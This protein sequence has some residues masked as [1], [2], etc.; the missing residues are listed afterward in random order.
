MT[1]PHVAVT[2]VR[3]FLVGAGLSNWVIV[4]VETDEGVHGVGDATLE[5]QSTAVAKLIDELKEPYLMEKSVFEIERFVSTVYAS[6]FWRGGPV[7]TSA[8]SGIEIAMWDAVGKLLGQS[9]F[10]LLGGRCHETI[11]AY[12][13]AWYRTSD[14]P[15][16]FA[17]EAT[18]VVERGYDAL[19]LDPLGS[20]QG[21]F[22]EQEF[23]NAVEI[24]RRIRKRVGDD[25]DI[26]VETHGRL[27]P[28]AARRFLLAVEEYHP[29]WYEE[30]VA[31]ELLDK[32]SDVCAGA[33]TRIALGERL[34]TKRAYRNLFRTTHVDTIQPDLGHVGGLLEGRKIA[35]MADAED[36][37]VAPHTGNSPVITAASLQLDVGIPNVLIQET[38]DDYDHPTL[39]LE[40][41]SG[42]PSVVDGRFSVPDRPGLGIEFNESACAKYPYIRNRYGRGLRDRNWPRRCW[43]E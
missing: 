19:K 28:H 39:R 40:M 38:F 30:P 41:F 10:T 16:Q 21:N 32:L 34:Y 36:C 23:R 3:A 27:L 35:A 37:T 15:A 25:V 31:N 14:D 11:R 43:Q 29:Y 6:S 20:T 1:A 17:D 13:N 8:V 18:G 42:L 4:R 9:V 7:L 5:G 12:A 2:D 33:S 26:L 22:T 24:V